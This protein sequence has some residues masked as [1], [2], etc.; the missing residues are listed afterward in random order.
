LVGRPE[1]RGPLGGLKHR[2]VD[3]IKMDLV[4][5]AWGGVDL[6]GWLRIDIVGELL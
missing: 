2:W 1:G 6:I 5:K 3:N 4:E